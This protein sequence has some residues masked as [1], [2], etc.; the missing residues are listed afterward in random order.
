M[1]TILRTIKT[2]SGEV[3]FLK[4][5]WGFFSSKGVKTSF[6]TIN[7]NLS[8]EVDI[9]VCEA[10]GCP[11]QIITD[12]ESIEEKWN[13]IAKTLK[14]RKIAEEDA[15]KAWLNGLDKKWILPK[16]IVIK[17]SKIDWSTIKD[18]LS[19]TPSG[20]IDILKIE[21]HDERMLLYSMIEQGARPG[22]LLVQYT[23]DPDSNVPAMLVA[24]H[25][26]NTGYKL[27]SVSD[28]NWFLYMYN[29]LCL[30]DSCS[31][32]DTTVNNPLVQYIGNQ[33]KNTVAPSLPVKDEK[34]EGGGEEEGTTK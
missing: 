1:N 31:W 3:P 10:L 26:Q 9:E 34:R 8:F 4:D 27:L 15:D 20:R 7:P 16:N 22:I 5:L 13:V 12:K 29:D 14:A 30:Y 17:P 33:L 18:V 23:E 25:L 32:R 6:V 24:G 11:I 28:T 21:S 2:E 19:T